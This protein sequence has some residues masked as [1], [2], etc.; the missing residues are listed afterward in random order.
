MAFL[1]HN[2]CWTAVLLAL[3]A[4]MN[5]PA[6]TATVAG[7][8]FE[9]GYLAMTATGTNSPRLAPDAG[10]AGGA[11]WGHHASASTSFKDVLG[12]GSLHALGADHWSVGDYFEFQTG[13]RGFANLA[14][15][16]DQYRSATGPTNWDFEY[17][18]DGSAF[19]TLSTYTVSN[20]SD[21]SSGTYR[22]AYTLT[23]DLSGVAT[24]A[25]ATSV[26]FR[27]VADSPPGGTA[28]AA[29]VDNFT[30]QGTVM[31]VPE[32]AATALLAAGGGL[33]LLCRRRARR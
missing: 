3:T 31:A 17:S 24:L 4:G 11:M 14:V 13:A 18:T 25:D 5:C 20:G 29:R 6:A 1:K 22:S 10:T 27:L 28:G 26:Y 9:T 15:S 23:F 30:L 8:D 7:W 12:N 32:P 16:F 19:T 33:L 21:W 2:R